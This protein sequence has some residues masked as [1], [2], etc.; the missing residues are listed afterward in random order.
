MATNLVV[1]NI[2]PAVTQALKRA[3]AAHGR[4]AEA[5]HREILRAALVRPLRRTFKEVLADMPDVG[6]D[7]DF[8][9]RRA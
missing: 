4:S 7:E 3:A 1:R 2:D 9:S 6:T 8:D 5:E